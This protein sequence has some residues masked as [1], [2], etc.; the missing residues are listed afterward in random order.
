MKNALRLGKIWIPNQV[1][2]GEVH[3]PVANDASISLPWGKSLSEG[4]DGALKFVGAAAWE[5]H[6]ALIKKEENQFL[7]LQHVLFI[8]RFS[9]A[10]LPGLCV[11]LL[12][13]KWRKETVMSACTRSL[14]ATEHREIW[15]DTE[16]VHFWSPSL[17]AKPP[18]NKQFSSI[19]AEF[20]IS[21]LTVLAGRNSECAELCALIQGNQPK[22]YS[23]DEKFLFW[24]KTTHANRSFLIEL[25]VQIL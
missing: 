14:A 19:T 23:N 24:K 21:F 9:S 6:K 25:P 22:S 13:R 7:L 5:N 20:S 1:V 10:H 4:R 16:T 18:Q 12:D 15:L 3:W 8:C 17:C 11:R 2:A